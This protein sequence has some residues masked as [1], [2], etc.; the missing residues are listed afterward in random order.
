MIK[1]LM[2]VTGTGLMSYK[3]ILRAIRAGIMMM[4]FQNGQSGYGKM[5]ITT[6]KQRIH[7]VV[8]NLVSDDYN[9]HIGVLNINI[10]KHVDIY[11][12]GN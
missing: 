4:T 5:K 11:K 7:I 10:H 3:T 1:T 8:G 9:L 12:Q 6:M 2:T